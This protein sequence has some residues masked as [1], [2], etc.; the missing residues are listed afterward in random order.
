MLLRLWTEEVCLR[1]KTGGAYSKYAAAVPCIWPSFRFSRAR[2][3]LLV[4]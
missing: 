3:K 1:L 2:T 4:S